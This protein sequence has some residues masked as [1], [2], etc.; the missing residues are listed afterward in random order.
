VEINLETLNDTRKKATV[1]VGADEVGQQ[2]RELVSE[3]KQQARLPG[4]RP[5][6]APEDMVRK[7]YR[8][9]IEEQLTRRLTQT[10]RMTG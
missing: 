10:L 7:R 3:F 8:K 9:D 5:G 2:E 1:K 4:F 6:K